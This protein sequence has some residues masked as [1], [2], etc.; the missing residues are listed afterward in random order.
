MPSTGIKLCGRERISRWSE[1]SKLFWPG[2][3][4]IAY[5]C[6]WRQRQCLLGVKK[7][8][9]ISLIPWDKSSKSWSVFTNT[10]T[11]A[12]CVW[13]M[14][15]HGEEKVCSRVSNERGKA[16]SS[17]AWIHATMGNALRSENL[18]SKICDRHKTLLV[19]FWQLHAT[20]RLPSKLVFFSGH[21][22]NPKSFFRRILMSACISADSLAQL[23]SHCSCAC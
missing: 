11:V 22:W 6:T 7:R 13:L 18:E 4:H 5:L 8:R 16:T 20:K 15:I 2:Q 23:R 12:E 1:K 10:V 9:R 14:V 19:S 3:V 17:P 21:T